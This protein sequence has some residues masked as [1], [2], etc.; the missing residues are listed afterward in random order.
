MSRWF[1]L[2]D[3]VVND[4]KVQSLPDALFRAW[5]NVLCVASKH[6]GQL[7]PLRDTAFI[8]RLTDAKA[9]EI[10]TKLCQVGLLDKDGD[11]FKPHNWDARQF[12]TDRA[13]PTNAARQKRYRNSRR[14]DESNV[15]HNVMDNSVTSVTDKRPYTET[16]THT[17]AEKKETRAG[18]LVANDGWP[19]DYREQ[20]WNRYPNKVGKPKALAKLDLARKHGAS[21]PEI[22]D[23]LDRYIASKPPDRAWLN[24]ETFINQERWTDQPAQVE[25]AKTGSSIIEASNRLVDTVRLFDEGAG[26]FDAIRGGEGAADVRL[27]S[28]R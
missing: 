10:L 26:R 18:A 25:N 24:P 28:S 2:D 17:E 1:R 4:P 3:D 14:N 9:A 12:R 15:T 27:L 6:G 11:T 13:D 7:P 8:L 16:D 20:F 19:A 22:M 5:V 21:F 23:G